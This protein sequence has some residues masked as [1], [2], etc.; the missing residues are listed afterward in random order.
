MSS[1]TTTNFAI[2]EAAP[3]R[4]EASG[5][6]SF[7]SAAQ[8]LTAGL[9]LIPRGQPCTV[10]LSRVKEAD[11]A[12]LAVLVEWLATARKRGTQ[13]HYEGIPAQILAVARISDLEDLLTNG[14]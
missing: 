3:G 13:V 6:M 2:R 14:G 7:E 8:A 12:G 11:S 1:S 9:A 5:M 10:D 4:L